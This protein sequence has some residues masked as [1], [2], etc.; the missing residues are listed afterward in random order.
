ME[1]V[2]QAPDG[3]VGKG[4]T[5]RVD[6]APDTWCTAAVPGT[7]VSTYEYHAAVMRSSGSAHLILVNVHLEK[8]HVRQLFAQLLEGR[9]DLLA[10]GAPS[11]SE[12]DAHQSI[13]T[14]RKNVFEL[15]LRDNLVDLLCRARSNDTA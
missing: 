1:R 4:S 6:Q 7:P 2:N 15:C 9:G 14:A 13:P 11:G 10:R 8:D 3:N 5:L 12:I